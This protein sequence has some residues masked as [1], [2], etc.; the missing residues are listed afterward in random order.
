MRKDGITEL[1]CFVDD[2]AKAYEK[3]VKDRQIS[4]GQHRNPTRTPTMSLGEM[5]TVMFLFHQSQ[6]KNFK[7]FY[8]N[9]L[10]EYKEEFPAMITYER[11]V[12][13]EPRIM[14]PFLALLSVIMSKATGIYYVDSSAALAVCH[15]K[16][17]RSNKVFKGLA[18]IGRTTMGWF[19]GFKLHLVVDEVGNLINFTLTKG[20]AGDTTVV[21]KITQHVHGLLF[22]DKGYISQRL[23]QELYQ[24]GLKLITSVKKTMKNKLISLHEKI[25]LR[26]RSVIESVFNVLKNKFQIAHSR[27]RSP[28]NAFV[29][30]VSTLAIY[31]LSPKK[32]SISCDYYLPANP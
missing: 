1:F 31:Q 17:I 21:N 30:I 19:F 12:A 29:H 32:P 15:N 27:H 6:Y 5:M 20:N 16:R 25:L 10:I 14:H 22:G 3:C 23:F 11:F 24:R 7:S 13:L 18:K 26:K 4:D 8:V 9:Q 2:F 28:V